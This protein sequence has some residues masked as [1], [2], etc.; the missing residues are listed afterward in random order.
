MEARA[1]EVEAQVNALDALVGTGEGEGL[2][3]TLA[4]LQTEVADLQAAVSEQDATLSMHE[5]EIEQVSDETAA[6]R[7]D[8]NANEAGIVANV[9]DIAANTG[10]ASTHATSIAA[11]QV[12][13]TSNTASIATNAATLAVVTGDYLT[14][15]EQA[16]LQAGIDGNTA[17]LATHAADVATNAAGIATNAA[18]IASIGADYLTSAEQGL[19]QNDI[20]QN[21]VDIDAVAGEVD[22]IQADYLPW[23]DDVSTFVDADTASGVV[24]VSGADLEVDQQI[25][26]ER[27]QF[28]N[29][30]STYTCTPT[31]C[32]ALCQSNGERMAFTDEVL[33]WASEGQGHC[34]WMW[35]LERDANAQASQPVMA[36]PMYSNRTTT[37]CGPTNTGDVPRLA[38]YSRP[39][40]GWSSTSTY[41]CACATLN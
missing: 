29:C 15:T 9:A 14:S 16:A 4:G 1:D 39:G 35:M 12:S 38:G 40:D 5:T 21:T 26:G 37:G 8:V 25:S 32:L 41:D 24:S 18:D 17:S 22:D 19:L 34:A 31:A 30:G 36:Y 10:A 7:V 2:T 3:E 33:A 13:L 23:I 6:L 20:I 11:T 27:L 28:R